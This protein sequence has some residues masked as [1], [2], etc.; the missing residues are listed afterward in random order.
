[1]TLS[2]GTL[3]GQTITFIVFVIFCKRYIWPPL[4]NA[5]QERQKAIAEGLSSAEKAE[6][7]LASAQER[8]ADELKEAKGE[9]QKLLEQARARANQMVEDA[10]TEAR[11]EGERI[12]EAARSEIDQEINRAKESL[13]GQVAALSVVG[14]EKILGDSVDAEKHSQLLSKLAEEL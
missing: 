5:M 10:K 8:V 14:A 4:I 12:K 6:Q 9:A 2:L 13:R 11:E 1:M 7:D 3:I